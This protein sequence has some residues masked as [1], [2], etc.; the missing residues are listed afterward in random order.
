[1]RAAKAL[2][3]FFVDDLELS[4]L[5]ESFGLCNFKLTSAQDACVDPAVQNVCDDIG[6]MKGAEAYGFEEGFV[7]ESLRLEFAGQGKP[8]A[9]T[10][11][12]RGGNGFALEVG[13]TANAACFKM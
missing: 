13:D 2:I 7:V 1:M 4:G 9:Q 5:N 10:V 6:D 11:G 8:S 12:Q 3:V